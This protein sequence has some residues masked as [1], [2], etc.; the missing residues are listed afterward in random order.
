VSFESELAAFVRRIVRDELDRAEL[1]R[2][3]PDWLT[4]EQ[5]GT[6]VG[7]TPGAIR[8]RL[9]NGWLRGHVVKDGRRTLIE[10]CALLD[11]LSRRRRA[12]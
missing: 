6:I 7:T 3:E 8:Q 9:A 4:T 2:S 1:E 12:G 10:R 11:D 5:A